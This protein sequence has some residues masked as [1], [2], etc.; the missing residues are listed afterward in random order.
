MN[1]KE[2]FMVSQYLNQD[3]KAPSDPRCLVDIKKKVDR[4]FYTD[5]IAGAHEGRFEIL[6]RMPFP[7]TSQAYIKSIKS[8]QFK[9]YSGRRS[10]FLSSARFPI[11]Y[12]IDSGHL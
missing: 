4:D 7:L 1:A 2:M 8:P 9:K 5:Y 11:D 3:V 6:N 10:L 12:R